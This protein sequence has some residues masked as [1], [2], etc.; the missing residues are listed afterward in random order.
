MNMFFILFFKTLHF[1]D[2]FDVV[3]HKLGSNSVH[4]NLE[5]T[6]AQD[7]MIFGDL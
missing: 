2:Y 3:M 1:T 5:I 4:G 7:T 6:T